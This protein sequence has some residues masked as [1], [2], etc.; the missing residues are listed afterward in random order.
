ME[1]IISILLVGAMFILG[2]VPSVYIL[3]SM[4]L[5]LG[6]KIYRKV[7]FGNSLYD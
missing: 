4:P 1:N 6:K 5:L 2:G 7:R 3:V